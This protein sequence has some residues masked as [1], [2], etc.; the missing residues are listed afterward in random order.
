MSQGFKVVLMSRYAFSSPYCVV[1]VA[2]VEVA[3]FQGKCTIDYSVSNNY[4][5][6]C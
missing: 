1:S 2:Q 4:T 5:A 6:L 3:S